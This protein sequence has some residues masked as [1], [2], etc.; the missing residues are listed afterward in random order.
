MGRWY[1]RLLAAVSA[2]MLCSATRVLAADPQ[3]SAPAESSGFYVGLLTGLSNTALTQQYD[4]NGIPLPP[5]QDLGYLGPR[6]SLRLG[7]DHPFGEHTSAGVLAEAS[8]TGSRYTYSLDGSNVYAKAS[9]DFSLAAGAR[10]GYHVNDRQTWFASAGLVSSEF[11]LDIVSPP[12]PF[13]PTPQRVIGG[14]AGV[15]IETKLGHGLALLLDARYTSFDWATLNANAFATWA[16]KPEEL[17]ARV[18]LVYR[19]QP[20]SNDPSAD[21]AIAFVP[22]PYLAFGAGLSGFNAMGSRLAPFDSEEVAQNG[23]SGFLQAGLDVEPVDG[24]IAGAFVDYGF[25]GLGLENVN[26][27]QFE[28]S[29]SLSFG[30]RVG[31]KLGSTLLFGSAGYVRA[32]L[33][34]KNGNNAAL[35]DGKQALGL[36]GLFVGAGTETMLN[37]TLALKFEYRVMDFRDAV[38][39]APGYPDVHLKDMHAHSVRLGLAIRF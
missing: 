1:A 28:Q 17:S 30:V 29:Q 2:A 36:D 38:S 15:E 8:M 33:D 10:F 14:F 27:F 39:S 16:M 18:G 20:S 34:V 11:A 12:T 5:S 21:D 22:G 32:D 24:V 25:S 7:W 37:D 13:S 26:R 31:P 35:Q 23:M 9:Q 6:Q 3:Q 4:D 19:A